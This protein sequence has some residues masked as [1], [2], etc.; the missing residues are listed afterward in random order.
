MALPIASIPEL[1]GEVAQRFEAEAQA[2]YQRDLNRTE[3]EKKAEAEA[4]ERGF[5][6]LRRML[7]KA[8]LGDK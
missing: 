4:L 8:H 5:A 2:K 3:E 6:K 1:T 7:A